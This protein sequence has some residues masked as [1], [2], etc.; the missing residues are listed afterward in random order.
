MADITQKDIQR[1]ESL[2]L[3]KWPQMLVWG[4]RVTPQQAQDIILRTDEFLTSL[5]Q[6]SGGNN[7]RWNSWARS[8]LGYDPFIVGDHK[9]LQWEVQRLL[10][11]RIGFVET[12]YVHNT[13]ASSSYIYGPYGWCHPD[14]TIWYGDNI[15]K[16]PS[17][18][19][20]FEEWQ[21]LAS[22]FPYLDLTVTLMSNEHC[23][24]DAEP[25]VSFRVQNGQVN[26]LDYPDMPKEEMPS[27]AVRDIQDAIAGFAS[28]TRE[29]GLPSEWIHQYSVITN[30]YLPELLKQAQQIREQAKD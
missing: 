9:E 30:G 24:D 23:E 25:V 12:S 5:Y 16:Y 26:I 17:A 8:V 2:A 15:G 19:E 28:P 21:L 13:W 3:P 18:R 29:Q 14:G 7:H 1:L 20:V 27:G 10:R 4:Q 6:Y 22:T 11:E